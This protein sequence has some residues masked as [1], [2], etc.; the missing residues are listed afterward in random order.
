MQQW[1]KKKKKEKKKKE[2]DRIKRMPCFPWVCTWLHVPVHRTH[3]HKRR[4]FGAHRRVPIFTLCSAG[5]GGRCILA[6]VGATVKEARP[7]QRAVAHTRVCA[8]AGWEHGV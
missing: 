7:C 6:R 2:R 4:C 5:A 1:D 3:D 8:H